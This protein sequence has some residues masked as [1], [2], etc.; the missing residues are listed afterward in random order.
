M[1]IPF[2][3]TLAG[4]L[5]LAAL[6]QPAFAFDGDHGRDRGRRSWHEWHQAEFY[7]PGFYRPWFYR[8]RRRVILGYY[9]PA[10]Y[11][12]PIAYYYPPPVYAAPAYS[13][14]TFNFRY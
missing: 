11:A 5:A 6:I 13:V 7:R 9:A 12:P 1:R 14:T 4:L 3:T 10:Y 8:P 2:K